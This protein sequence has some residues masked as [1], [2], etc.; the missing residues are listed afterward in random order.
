VAALVGALAASLGVMGARLNRHIDKE[1]DLTQLKNR[2][3]QLG[4]ED[5]EAYRSLLEAY[6]I[7][8]HIPDRPKAI[9]VALHRAT[10]IPLEIAELA[11]KAGWLLHTICKSAKPLVLAD[12]TV[13]LQMALTASAAALLIVN[14]N[15][16][17]QLNQ[18]LNEVFLSRIR[19]TEQS[20]EELKALCYTPPLNS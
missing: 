19:E 7:P 2:L 6:K 18:Q 1:R 13:G 12:M 9:T 16:K 11:C 3:R 15:E 17:Y 8:K 14:T 20:L 10:E 4:Q 5:A